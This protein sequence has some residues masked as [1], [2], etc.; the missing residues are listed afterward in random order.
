MSNVDALDEATVETGQVVDH[1]TNWERYQDDIY[2][3]EYGHWYAERFVHADTECQQALDLLS[4]M[5]AIGMSVANV[6]G[7]RV[8]WDNR[9]RTDEGDV[10]VRVRAA[11]DNKRVQPWDKTKLLIAAG[12]VEPDSK[13]KR[14]FGIKGLNQDEMR[15]VLLAQLVGEI[16]GMIGELEY[17]VESVDSP[18]KT[19]ILQRPFDPGVNSAIN[20]A[21]HDLNVNVSKLKESNLWF[22]RT[23]KWLMAIDTLTALRQAHEFKQIFDSILPNRVPDAAASLSPRLRRRLARLTQS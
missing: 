1:R 22:S 7:L 12:E 5:G 10:I 18:V 15:G 23:V 8:M 17:V 21:R 9:V 13:Q 2:A 11:L 16:P 20:I 3:I 4:R 19:G 6:G 14:Q